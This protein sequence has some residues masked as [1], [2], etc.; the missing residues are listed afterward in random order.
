MRLRDDPEAEN[1]GRWLLQIGHSQI[2]DEHNKIEIPHDIH[3]KDIDSLQDFVYPNLNSIPPPSP[4]YFLNRM[5]LS[6]RN[7]DVNDVNEA[8]LKKMSGNVKTYYSVDEVIHEPGGDDD[9]HL[10]I[11]P[12]FL[13][14]IR[15]S[16]LPPGELNIKIGCPLILM[17]NLSPSDGLC[18]GTRMIVIGMTERVLQV[19]LLGGDHNGQVA[20]IPRISLI[21]TA[22][23]NLFFKLKRRQFPVRLAFAITI[24]RARGQSVKHVGLDLWTPVFAHGQLYV[25]LSRCHV[26]SASRPSRAFPCVPVHSRSVSIVLSCSRYF[27]SPYYYV[28]CLSPLLLHISIS[29][30]GRDELDQ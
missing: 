28:P 12:E 8:L 27:P 1:F 16:S 20:F 30:S 9:N 21:P 17:R 23:P 25:A 6:P 14:S 22:T 4:E 24:N 3:S 10:P 5:I 11:T 19:Q 26:P 18:N 7:S 15:S 29:G 2:S 13:R